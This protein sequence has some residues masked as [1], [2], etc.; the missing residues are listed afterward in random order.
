[1]KT[2]IQER[3]RELGF[4]ACHFTTATP[5]DHHEEFTQWLQKNYQGQMAWLERN[6]PKRIN[7]QLVLDGA[8]AIITLAVSYDRPGVPPSRSTGVIARY[9][10]FTDYHD[11]LAERL[12]L[13]TA[14]VQELSPG[15]RSLWYVDTG[16]LLERDIAQRAGLGFVGKHTNL[17]SRNLGNWIFLCEIITTAEIPP[18]IP[19]KNRCGTCTRCITACPTAAIRGPFELDARR[20][21]SYL[22]IELKGSIPLEFRKAIGNRIY[23][24]DDCLAACP[25][26]RFARE[27]QIMKQHARAELDTPDLIQLLCLDDAEFK[28]MFAGSPILRTKRRGF[29]RNVCVALGNIGTPAALPALERAQ[30]DAEPLI[31]E[32]AEWAIEQIKLRHPEHST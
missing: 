18:D 25:W 28:K 11:I 7:P 10:R 17:I 20:C 3:A 6:A 15:A 30:N 12:K 32:H 16:P 29:L 21:I 31:V 19:E 22:T 8:K 4:D 23:G 14:Y 9:A 26:N 5:P 27:G 13:L 2:A 24:C 1:M